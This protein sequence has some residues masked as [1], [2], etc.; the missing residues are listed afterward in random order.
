MFGTKPE[1]INMENP[2]TRMMELKTTAR[3]ASVTARWMAY[4]LELP[5]LF[6]LT[7]RDMT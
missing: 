3:P 1:N 2:E 5:S 4:S 6:A 7:K